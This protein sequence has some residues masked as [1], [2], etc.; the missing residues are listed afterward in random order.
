MGGKT[1]HI[2]LNKQHQA[3]EMIFLTDRLMDITRVMGYITGERRMCPTFL[4]TKDKIT[5]FNHL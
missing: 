4:L 3:S 2:I 5:I 1:N